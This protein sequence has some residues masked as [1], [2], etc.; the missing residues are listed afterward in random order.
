MS[1]RRRRSLPD[2]SP[3]AELSQS[4]FAKVGGR[5][6]SVTA[7][8]KAGALLAGVGGAERAS[9]RIPPKE[10]CS[11]HTGGR[12]V[13]AYHRTLSPIRICQH[14][15]LLPSRFRSP[16]CG[17]DSVQIHIDGQLNARSYRSSRRH[18]AARRYPLD[19]D[20]SLRGL[21]QTTRVLRR[22]RGSLRNSAS[23]SPLRHPLLWQHHQ[24]SGT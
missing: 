23:R 18:V 3:E 9:A 1:K 13:A 19:A 5:A 20:R 17:T 8:F 4:C 11:P 12:L 10:E 24:V 7:T 14:S 15:G 6:G 16:L 21:V 2:F 22:V